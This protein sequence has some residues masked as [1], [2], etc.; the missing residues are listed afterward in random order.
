LS[1]KVAVVAGANRGWE[2]HGLPQTLDPALV[3]L[4]SDASRFTTAAMLVIDG[5]YT[6]H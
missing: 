6:V 2:R 1:G 3:C 5:G 4:A